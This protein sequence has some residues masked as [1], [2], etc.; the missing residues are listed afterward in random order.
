MIDGGGA[1]LGPLPVHAAID[2]FDQIA[3]LHLLRARAVEIGLAEE[4]PGD[5]KRRIDRRQLALF[6]PL[7]RLHV[8]EMIK[9]ALVAG[10]AASIRVLRRVTKEAQGRE[11]PLS[12]RLARDIA[13]FDANGIGGQAETNRRDAGKGR[14]RKSIRYKAVLPICRV[15]EKAERALLELDD[16][17]GRAPV[18]RSGRPPTLPGIER[19]WCREQARRSGRQSRSPQNR[20]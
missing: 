11:H 17:T 10:C 14:R 13:T 16:E 20:E 3:N 12:R 18:S 19:V 8:E 7:A 9:K 4:G 2:L 5:K 6:E 15:P 1:H